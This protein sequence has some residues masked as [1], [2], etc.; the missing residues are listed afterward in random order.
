MARKTKTKKEIRT[1]DNSEIEKLY[2]VK[3]VAEI[4]SVNP[5]TVRAWMKQGKLNFVLLKP[6]VKDKYRIKE[7]ELKKIIKEGTTI[8]N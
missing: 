1:Q 4:L 8:G 5:R 7:S 6:G 3:E 2:A